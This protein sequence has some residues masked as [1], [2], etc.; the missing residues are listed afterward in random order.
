MDSKKHFTPLYP[1]TV[2]TNGSGDTTYDY[3]VVFFITAVAVI[4]S[5]V[6]SIFD[7]KTK[8]YNRLFYWVCVIIRYYVA[9]TMLAYGFV[10]SLNCNFRFFLLTSYYNLTEVHLQWDLHGIF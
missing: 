10:K 4:T 2:F 7:K 9:I 5:L 3:V 8:S 6:W 1:V